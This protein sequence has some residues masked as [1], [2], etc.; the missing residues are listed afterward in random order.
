[1]TNLPGWRD[2]T[3]SAFSRA[4]SAAMSPGAE[5]PEVCCTARSSI[6]A[7]TASKLKPALAS[8]VCRARLC[9]ARING[10]FPRQTLISQAG[11]FHEPLPLPV[12]KQLQHGGG[13]FLDRSPGHVELYPIESGAQSP[14]KCDFICDR[15]T[16]DI[17][18]V[19]GAG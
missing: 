2:D 14:R 16:I 18:V 10:Y 4:R 13:S 3:E 19:A 5:R 7:A 1:M 17:I 11:S 15:L 6:S 12:G 9:E 8:S